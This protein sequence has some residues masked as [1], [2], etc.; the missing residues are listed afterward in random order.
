MGDNN[1]INTGYKNLH[2]SAA[3]FL[4]PFIGQGETPYISLQGNANS[5]DLENVA[6][7]FNQLFEMIN[8]KDATQDYLKMSDFPSNRRF[9]FDTIL[10]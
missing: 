4:G 9:A 10:L 2:T 7:E 1:E 6:N 3:F 8:K 5:E